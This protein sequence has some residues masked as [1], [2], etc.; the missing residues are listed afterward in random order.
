M[1]GHIQKLVKKDLGIVIS[2]HYFLRYFE[3]NFSKGYVYIK[4]GPKVESTGSKHCVVLQFRDVKSV[5]IVGSG[6]TKID[7]AFP[8]NWHKNGLKLVTSDKTY[9]LFAKFEAVM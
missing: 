5:E 9:L 1:S 6:V 7:E 2:H 3:I 8:E 4:H